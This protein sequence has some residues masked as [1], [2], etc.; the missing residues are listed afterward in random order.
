MIIKRVFLTV[1]SICFLMVSLDLTAAMSKAKSQFGL[2]ALSR[3]DFNE[4]AIEQSIPLY[5]YQDKGNQGK[6]DP[7]EVI[8]VGIDEK[9][10]DYVKDG[11]FTHRFK[12]A[13]MK[14][15]EAKRKDL[16]RSELRQGRPAV[17][18]TD[19][20]GYPDD[21]RE[22]VEY[23]L[24]AS[25]I[26]ERL[27][28]IQKGGLDYKNDIPSKDR[29]SRALYERNQGVWCEAIETENSPFCHAHPD[30]PIKK[31]NAY[32]Q[33]LSQDEKMCQMLKSQPNGKELLAPFAVVRRKGD[34]FIALP[35]NHP[36]VYGS[37]MKKIASLLKKAA[38]AFVPGKEEALK[39]YLLAAAEGFETN[40]W[41][42][43]DEAWAAM[44]PDNSKWY[45]RIAPDEVYY[46]P[47]Q[48][49]AGF[50]VSFA[51]ISKGSKKWK[52]KLNP[53][54]QEME[55][56][57]ADLIGSS[58]KARKVGFE[59]PEF[60]DIVL[61]AGDSRKSL[62][63]TV[64]QS[65]PN[66][67]PVAEEGRG[68]TVAMT[69]FYS[70]PESMEYATRK[71]RLFF[72]D[73]TMKYFDPSRN[74]SMLNTILH[75]ATHNFGPHSDYKIKGKTPKVLFG[76]RMASILE[77]LKADTGGIW[78]AQFLHKKGLITKE[79]LYKQYTDF[80]FSCFNHISRGMYTPGGNPKVYSQISAIQIGTLLKD[81]AL[82]KVKVK[83]PKNK[84]ITWK[85]R[86]NFGKFGK[87][88]ERLIAKAAKIKATGSEGTAKKMVKY[89][90]KG[91]GSK[92]IPMQ[93]IG[94][95]YRSYPKE[96]YYYSVKLN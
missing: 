89:Y 62:L 78:F 27:Y 79:R 36:K 39:K 67:G 68:R 29:L 63:A 21:E 51:L 86:I 69:N 9:I 72:D 20:S 59:M 46:D 33:D 13:Y 34:G 10:E 82:V 54:R 71:A 90:V 87:S 60:I 85:Y 56:K 31:S 66:W 53:L 50:H 11:K 3:A 23:I 57:L 70:D 28:Q 88:M 30:F 22:F 37:Q 4:L 43:A 77:E 80:V 91:S 24:K 6:V 73:A 12:A 61:N 7:A 18:F 76:G 8:T 94:R 44:N 38:K 1:I 14:L 15:V 55:K 17:I 83:D 2:P 81:G 92:R 49:K 26:I 95:R 58:Y 41:E 96:N 65:L 40:K 45:L 75:E 64:G 35:Y 19:M 32:P 5:W 25:E 42:K 93:E 74:I 16:L 48:Q 84:N 47:C 52:E